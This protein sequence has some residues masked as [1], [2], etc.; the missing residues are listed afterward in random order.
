MAQRQIAEAFPPGEFLREELEARGWSQQDLADILGRTPTVVSQVLTGKRE[1]APELAKDLGA[2]FGVDPQFFM[3]LESAYRLFLAEQAD[4]AVARR[5]HLYS[6]VPIKEMI[7]RHWIEPSDSI[8]VLEKRVTD[9]LAVPCAR[10]AYARKSTSYYTF[11]PSVEAWVCRAARLAKAVSVTGQ[12]SDTAARAALEKLRKLMSHAEEVRNVPRILAESGIRFLIV[13]HL[14]QTRIDGATF[15]LNEQSPVIVLSLRYDRLDWFW[16]TLLHEM[17]HAIKRHGLSEEDD[18][19]IDIAL[20]GEDAVRPE[21]RPQ[22]EKDADTFAANFSIN[23]PDL[24]GFI[25]RV[26]P[27]YSKEKIKGFAM[28]RGIHPA[29]VVGQLQFRREIPYSHSRELLSKVRPI[30]TASALTDGWGQELPAKL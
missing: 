19:P 13:E 12:F 25:A 4:T 1:I 20:V 17:D 3:N 22:R 16:H 28:L 10:A 27:L 15:W 8:E 18:I 11:N 26:R 24:D 21:E 30:V 6:R 29:I 5:A 9:F 7:K 14:P 23:K 2:A